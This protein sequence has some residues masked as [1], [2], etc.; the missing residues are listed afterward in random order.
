MDLLLGL[1]WASK[2]IFDYN[3]E[4]YK[5]DQEQRLEKDMQRVEMQIKRFDLF[6]EDIDDLVKLTVSKMDM[7]HVVG[8]LFL[9]FT[10]LIYCEGIINKGDPPSFFMGQYLLTVASAFAFLLLAVWLA[11]YAS[12][13]SHSF[14]V[15]L[16]TR[17]VRLPIPNLDQIQ[18]LTTQLSQFEQQ[19]LSKMM[20]LPLGPQG[21]QKWTLEA[22]R[23]S[24]EAAS[25]AAGAAAQHT[26]L[27][28]TNLGRMGDV[29]FAREDILMQAAQTLPGKHVELFRKLQAKWQSYDAYARVAMGM[30]VYKL[31]QSVNYY[32]IGICLIEKCSPSCAVAATIILQSCTFGI[33]F[34]DFSGISKR[35]IIGLSILGSSSTFIALCML[36]VGNI[37]RGAEDS[38]NSQ[39]K[40]FYIA[41]ACA[42]LEAIWLQAFIE[43]SRPSNDDAG[44]PRKFRMILYLDVFGNGHYDPTEAEHATVSD[45]VDGDHSSDAGASA[46]SRFVLE[47]KAALI[48]HA[49]TEGHSALRRWEAVPE[50]LLSAD[51]QRILQGL[52]EDYQIVRRTLHGFYARKNRS[53]ARYNEERTDAREMRALQDLSVQEQS[54][55]EFYGFLL[56]PLQRRGPQDAAPQ[57]YNVEA[58]RTVWDLNP[59]SRVLIL[60]RAKELVEACDQEVNRLLAAER[61]CENISGSRQMHAADRLERKKKLT[62]KQRLPWKSLRRMTGVLQFCWMVLC[63]RWALDKAGVWTSVWG[64]ELPLRRLRSGMMHW[65]ENLEE[66]RVHWP[67]GEF[68]R[69]ESLACQAAALDSDS[70][71]VQIMLGSPYFWYRSVDSA[72]SRDGRLEFAP[73]P[74]DDFPAEA[75]VVHC[76]SGLPDLMAG[77]CLAAMLRDDGKELVLWRISDDRIGA[78]DAVVLS[79]EG[80]PWLTFSGSVLP[81]QST[82]QLLSPGSDLTEGSCLLLA[83]W[84]G[85]RLPLATVPLTEKLLSATGSA[86]TSWSVSP[87]VDA[88]ISDLEEDSNE[89]AQMFETLNL[90]L[91]SH[92]RGCRL[93][94]LLPA[95]QVLLAWDMSSLRAMG[96]WQLSATGE[97]AAICE[98]SGHALLLAGRSS[99]QEPRLWRSL[100]PWQPEESVS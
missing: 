75:V 64:P 70:R 50:D 87:R 56:G 49:M 29:G 45:G 12:I 40:A 98:T 35:L 57:Y 15:R 60:E 73:L 74:A 76:A 59:D 83:G 30:G 77:P 48:E 31:I 67:H 38:I 10:A 34:L 88:P 1:G 96:Q 54:E 36:I 66:L 44:L 7:Y 63:V 94:A 41:P 37:G 11:M 28:E 4:N 80:M 16:R 53:G 21:A 81:C 39:S 5:F 68:F 42:V 89:S 6:R 95:R 82:R 79:V 14:G 58:G 72:D 61:G 2:E 24:Q 78:P 47:Q 100:L 90:H 99:T 69:P 17:Y 92:V 19:K 3:R 62:G 23:R 8:A 91:T 26:P 97:T 33:I 27:P 32:V 52:R 55:D 65:P 25:S 51:Q 18:G 43:L 20:R 71:H 86:N 84:D 13:A 22:Q 9:S 85:T 46:E 93:W